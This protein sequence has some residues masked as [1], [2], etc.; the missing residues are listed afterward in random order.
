MKL[1]REDLDQDTVMDFFI[2]GKLVNSSLMLMVYWTNPD[3]EDFFA[4]KAK[5]NY[6]Y[7]ELWGKG[8]CVNEEYYDNFCDF[9]DKKRGFEVFKESFLAEQEKVLLRVNLENNLENK[10]QKNRIKI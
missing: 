5:G 8:F 2:K 10:S 9:F 4:M 3:N 1:I 7:K 6:K